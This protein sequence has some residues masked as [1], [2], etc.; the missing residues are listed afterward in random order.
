MNQRQEDVLRDSNIEWSLFYISR[1]GNKGKVM[2]RSAGTCGYHM[3]D[4]PAFIGENLAD[5]VD[6][7][8][9]WGSKSGMISFRDY[10]KE[11]S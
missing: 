9:A 5:C 2:L 11:S 6:Q 4:M 7:L 3:P 8:I 1:G 10:G